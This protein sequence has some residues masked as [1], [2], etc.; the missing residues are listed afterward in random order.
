MAQKFY[1]FCTGAVAEIITKTGS[2]RISRLSRF[3]SLEKTQKRGIADQ[4]EATSVV[5]IESLSRKR[6]TSADSE[7]FKSM[8][9][10]I[11]EGIDITF[12]DSKFFKHGP[13][14]FI[15]SYSA[16]NELAKLKADMLKRHPE[17]DSCVEILNPDLLEHRLWHR[18]EIATSGARIREV[19]SYIGRRDVEYGNAIHN[20]DNTIMRDPSPFFKDTFFSYQQEQRIILA[21]AD[22]NLPQYID[23]II[24]RPQNLFALASG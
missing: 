4:L 18:G 16:T 6:I 8:G 2:I 12:T 15:F 21:P 20:F 17:Y 5:H 14:L 7:I 9:V 13:D 22:Q 3:Q 10:F 1:K 23:V 24:P 19:F 11:D